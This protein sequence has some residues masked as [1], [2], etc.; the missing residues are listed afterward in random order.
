[1]QLRSFIF[2]LEYHI[3]G[4][5]IICTGYLSNNLHFMYDNSEQLA[6]EVIMEHCDK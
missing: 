1:M 2:S 4:H 5:R 3:V 6:V